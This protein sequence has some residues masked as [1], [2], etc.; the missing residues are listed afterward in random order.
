MTTQTA[1][2]AQSF[3]TSTNIGD[4]KFSANPLTLGAATSAYVVN[5][6]IIGTAPEPNTEVRVWYTTCFETTTAANAPRQ[7]GATARYIDTKMNQDGTTSFTSKKDSAL[8]P[9]TGGFFNC[10][11]SAPKLSAAATITVTLVELP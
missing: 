8:E 9:V 6:K 10:W 3:G 4:D 5:V 11:V 1:I 2:N 7:L